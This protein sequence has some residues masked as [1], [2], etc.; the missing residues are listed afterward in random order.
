MNNFSDKKIF[1]I[2]DET[3]GSRLDIFISQNYTDISRAK[4]QRGIKSGIILVNNEKVRKRTVLKEGDKVE[5]DQESL[6]LHYEISLK[7]Q[8]LD[9]EILFEDEYYVAINKPSGLVVHPGIGNYDGTL[10]NALLYRYKSLSTGSSYDR[11]GIVHRLDKNTSG[12]IV[13]AKN[14]EAHNALASLFAE[15]SIIKKYSGLCIGKHPKEKATINA[16]IGRKKNDPLRF[17]I[18]ESGKEAITDYSLITYHSGISLL[19]L[20][21]HTGRTHQIR[22]HCQHSGFPII[23]DNLYGGEKDKVLKLQPLDRPFA[24]KVCKC[25]TRQALH[26]REIS[27][28]HPF[29]Q[30]TLSIKAPFHEDFQKAIDAF[31]SVQIGKLGDV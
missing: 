7:P 4:I 27:F 25:F 18:L 22:V 14:D 17:C 9:L 30:K 24:Y 3:E 6:K 2:T 19:S 26:A 5:V 13:V 28:T 29:T 23:K 21:L 16:P 15:R 8:E 20:Q 1:D 12:V 31:W 11:P 10:V